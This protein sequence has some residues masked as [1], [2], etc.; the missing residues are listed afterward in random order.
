MGNRIAAVQMLRFSAAVGVLLLHAELIGYHTGRFLGVEL[1]RSYWIGRGGFGV[2][3]FFVI[4]GFIMV[5]SSARQVG[6][7]GARWTFLRRRLIRIVPLYWLGTLVI[8]AW[9]VKFGPKPDL[10]SLVTSFAFIPYAST[11]S[12][13]RISPLLEVGWTLNFEM[14][15]YGLF[16]L[17]MG[18][19]IK[20][21]V[22]RLTVLLSV[23]VLIGL[24]IALPLPLWFWTRPI[25]LEFL[26]GMWLGVIYM[27]GVALPVL[28]RWALICIAL[29][30]LGI[31]DVE[32]GEAMSG[33]G[34]MATWG[35]AGGCL[36]AA[37][38]LGETAL[39]VPKVL[40]WGGDISYAIYI[41]H[42]P[43]MLAAQMAWRHFRLPYGAMQ[44][45]GFVLGV[46]VLSLVVAAIAHHVFE[47]PIIRWLNRK[48][49]AV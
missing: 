17:A 40:V 47:R 49:A 25:L 32:G 42:M 14:L 28:A 1:E 6:K 48:E 26:C 8:V 13:G 37:V 24:M 22:A 9:F 15:F 7:T 41:V 35:L 19:G 18:K 2:D 21:T 36:L 16:A 27:R 4:S 34:R 43:L 23:L 46:T 11:G 44:E 45:I 3:L 33:L 12:S 29:V 31:G 20:Q 39:P 38:V 10:A 30:L 5:H